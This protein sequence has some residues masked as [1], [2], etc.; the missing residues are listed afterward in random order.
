MTANPTV[1]TGRA[2]GMVRDFV[3]KVS[4]LRWMRFN[5]SVPV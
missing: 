5:N 3:E 4:F 2:G 1:V